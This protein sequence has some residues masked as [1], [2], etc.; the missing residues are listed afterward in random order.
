MLYTSD[1]LPDEETNRAMKPWK[2]LIDA[3]ANRKIG[4]SL[5]P[6]LKDDCGTG[7][8][9]LGNFVTDAFV[10]YYATKMPHGPNEWTSA[11]ISIIQYGGIR[12]TLGKGGKFLPMCFVFSTIN[13]NP[14]TISITKDISFGDLVTTLPFESTVDAFDVR[15]DH[16]K[17]ALEFSVSKSSHSNSGR[18]FSWIMLQF[19]GLK[20]V[21]N[22]TQPVNERVVSVHA[23]CQKCMEPRYE[24]LNLTSYYRVITQ[25]YLARAGDGFRMLADNK[26]NYR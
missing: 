16:L 19:S 20:V 9:N 23:L 21:Y 2:K 11:S 3:E 12:T 4:T 6:L 10:Y 25:D 22:V 8:C 1:Y 7:E 5:F 15:G 18:F 24:P 17:E 26:K 13:I 14:S